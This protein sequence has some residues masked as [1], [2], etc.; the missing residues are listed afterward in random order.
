[1]KKSEENILLFLDTADERFK[2][3]RYISVKLNID[4]SYLIGLLSNLKHKGYISPVRRGNR[5]F[6]KTKSLGIDKVNK[7]KEQRI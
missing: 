1:M 6:Y 2:Y 4:Y 7:I 3:A 5:V